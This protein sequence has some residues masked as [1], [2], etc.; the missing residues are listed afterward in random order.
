MSD[1][2]LKQSWSVVCFYPADFTFV[3]PTE[4]SD[5]QD[6]Y[7]TLKSLDVEVYSVSADTHFTH[8]AWHDRQLKVSLSLIIEH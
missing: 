7:E 4:L 2:T 1:L 6:Q 3:C 8:K 5:L